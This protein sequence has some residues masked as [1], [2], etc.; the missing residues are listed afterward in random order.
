VFGGLENIKKMPR[1]R[2]VVL[3]SG[4]LD[5]T[6]S[7]LWALKEFDEIKVVFFDYSQIAYEAEKRSV[8]RI[9]QKYKIEVFEDKVDVLKK[10]AHPL[11]DENAIKARKSMWVPA[12]NVVFLSHAIAFAEFYGFNAVVI[13]FNADEGADFPD[14]T[15][16]FLDAFNEL[17][18]MTSPVRVVSPFVQ[19]SKAEIVKYIYNYDRELLY[20]VH[21]CY[22]NE[23]LNCGRCESC[24]RFKKALE[25]LK[26]L[27]L[28]YTRIFL[29]N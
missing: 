19:K 25:S 15:L 6:A 16:E 10:I 23:K 4:G 24:L 20:L 13:G 1:K 17:L 8:Y 21:P 14:N 2:A 27:K 7:F 18:K 29:E 11:K 26:E 9:A 28:D 12:R 5:S 22:L 3:L